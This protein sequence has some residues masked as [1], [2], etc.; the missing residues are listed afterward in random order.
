MYNK[1]PAYQIISGR[2]AIVIAFVVFL[3]AAYNSYFIASHPDS[4]EV[5]MEEQEGCRAELYDLASYH[6][7]SQ[8]KHPSGPRH[9]KHYYLHSK[10]SRKSIARAADAVSYSWAGQYAPSMHKV[11][12]FA[13]QARDWLPVPGYYTLLHL[14]ALF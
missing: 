14:L 6:G 2:L 12:P 7:E 1:R 3:F 5:S 13:M 11:H 10:Q 9:K 4:V 8:L